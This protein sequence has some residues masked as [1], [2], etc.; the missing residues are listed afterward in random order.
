MAIVDPTCFI[1]ASTILPYFAPRTRLN[2]LVSR[3]SREAIPLQFRHTRPTHNHVFCAQS[4]LHVEADH[5]LFDPTSTEVDALYNTRLEESKMGSQSLADALEVGGSGLSGAGGEGGDDSGASGRGS[6]GDNA[7]DEDYSEDS[8]PDDMKAALA[9]GSISGDAVSRYLKA[10]KNPVTRFLLTFGSFRSRFLVDS[11][12]LFKLLVQEVIGN[13]T[14]LAS[15]IAVRGKEIVHEVEYVASDLIVGTVI[16]AAFV[17]LLAPTLVL[18]SGGNVSA[19]ARYVTALPSH[20]FQA[21]SP[22]QSFSVG[23]RVASFV[24]AGGQYALIGFVGGVVGTAITYALLEGRKRLD[25]GY[26]PMR[27][28]PAVIPNS[29]GWAAFMALSSNTRFQIVE[30]MELGIAQ[31]LTGSSAS[32]VNPAIIALRFVNNYWGGVQFVQFFRAI[33]LHATGQEDDK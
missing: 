26:T 33:G 1:N 4:P 17:W 22:L 3:T 31:M 2:A 8:L 11:S 16:E 20:M 28:M 27:P 5:G 32:L 21:A 29:A 15:E 7:G 23:Q 6:G 12:F 13:G 25:E 30:G 24:Y 19:L 14:A 9:Y 18:P 10:M